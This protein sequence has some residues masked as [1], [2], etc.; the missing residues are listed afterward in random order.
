MPAVRGRGERLRAS[1]P[2]HWAVQPLTSGQRHQSLP[3][4]GSRSSLS[5]GPRSIS[6]VVPRSDSTSMSA[7]PRVGTRCARWS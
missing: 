5:L 6:W 7:W 4:P 3:T 1:G 2:L